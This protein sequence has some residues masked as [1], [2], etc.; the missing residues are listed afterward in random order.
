MRIIPNYDLCMKKFSS[1]GFNLTMIIQYPRILKTR[2]VFDVVIFGNIR[3]LEYHDHVDIFLD[4]L[5][6]Y[7][8]HL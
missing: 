8:E 7:K 5:A 4:A 6:L 2:S 3:L 1:L